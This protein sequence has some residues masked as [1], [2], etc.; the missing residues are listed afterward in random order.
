[1]KKFNV[2]LSTIN[3]QGVYPAWGETENIEIE[4]SNH[5]ELEK[6]IQ[7]LKEDFISS[8]LTNNSDYTSSDILGFDLCKNE[9]YLTVETYSE[10]IE[11]KKSEFILS[12]THM[13]DEEG[14]RL[15]T[16]GSGEPWETCSAPL[17]HEY[18]G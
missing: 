9:I 14:C 10:E 6:E 17:G 3:S 13:Y 11:T 8:L 7:N 5:A 12:P 4:V 1:M 2:N 15:C 16:C 18:C